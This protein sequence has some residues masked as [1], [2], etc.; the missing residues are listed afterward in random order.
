MKRFLIST[1]TLLISA[2]CASAY[3][4]A[5]IQV[6]ANVA[7]NCS[8]AANPVAF[9]AY[10]PVGTNASTP[11]DASGS[12]VVTCTKGALGVVVSLNDGLN[13]TLGVRQ[14]LGTD[15]SE[16]LAYDLYQPIDA[17]PSAACAY[18]TLWGD[19]T[20]NATFSPDGQN[21]GAGV[22]RTYN[23]CGRIPAGQNVA[24]D[25]AYTDTVVATVTF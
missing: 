5:N 15:N 4:Q 22:P 2:L 3:G 13:V 7:E 1:A 24:T 21:W 17:T 23:V 25:S 20:P 14:M 12:V 10:D 19:G 11:R 16:L 9:G 6:T 18:T 8:I